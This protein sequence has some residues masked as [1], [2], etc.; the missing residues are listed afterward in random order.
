[1]LYEY[2]D[3]FL[4]CQTAVTS[5]GSRGKAF[6]LLG[7]LDGNQPSLSVTGRGL[8]ISGEESR[9]KSCRHAQ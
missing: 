1:M 3:G 7:M 5:K 8:A 4:A 6:E 2:C 9:H